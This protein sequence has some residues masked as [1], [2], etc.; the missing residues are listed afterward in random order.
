MAKRAGVAKAVEEISEALP[1]LIRLPRGRAWIDYDEEA[2]V[3]YVSLQRPQKATDTEFLE[4]KGILLRYRDKELVGVTVLDA[5]K[6][7]K[8]NKRGS[9]RN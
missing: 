6:R 4:K 5:S 3:L 8:E 9:R 2:D 7:G 1:H